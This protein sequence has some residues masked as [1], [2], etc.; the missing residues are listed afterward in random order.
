MNH[1]GCDTSE[2]EELFQKLKGGRSK[3]DR[4]R[5]TTGIQ[6]RLIKKGEENN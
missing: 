4:T 3:I 5:P 1:G 2:S 6:I